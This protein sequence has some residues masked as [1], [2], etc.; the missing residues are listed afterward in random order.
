MASSSKQDS[1]NHVDNDG[2][3]DTLKE[4]TDLSSFGEYLKNKFNDLKKDVSEGVSHMADKAAE[5]IHEHPYVVKALFAVVAAGVGSVTAGVGAI[6]IAA[7]LAV[8]E[9][10]LKDAADNRVEEM[11]GEKLNHHTNENPHE[12]DG[13]DLQHTHGID[14]AQ[15]V[16]K[17]DLKAMMDIM[18]HFQDQDKDNISKQGKENVSQKDL[19]VL[20]KV[21][22]NLAQAMSKQGN[23]KEAAR[24]GEREV[25]NNSMT[26]S[27]NRT[28][29][30]HREREDNRRQNN[31]GKSGGMVI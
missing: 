25:L 20:A 7:V 5:F 2:R 3:V 22:L 13:I 8:G 12:N 14:L 11:N 21:L 4:V 15:H 10:F 9:K 27:L 16:N 29:S 19:E 30:T 26:I 17:N 6:P 18:R 24:E 31:S 28:A 1:V 23:I